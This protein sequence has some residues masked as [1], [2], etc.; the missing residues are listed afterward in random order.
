[1]LAKGKL[2]FFLLIGG[3]VV[4]A[5]LTSWLDWGKSRVDFNT[6]I[7]PI[8]NAN[9]TGCH[10]GVKQQGGISLL[11][12]ESALAK[13]KSGKPCIVPGYPDQSE[14]ILRL[15]HHD[16]DERMPLKAPPLT[17]EQIALLANW[18]KE[19]ASWE[20]H[21]AYILPVAITPPSVW[22]RW[23]ESPIDQFIYKKLD[24]EGL[25]PS[26]EADR[27]TL[28]RRVTLDL[29]GLAPTA[30]AYDA[31]LKDESD[32]AYEKVVDN[33][34][35]SPGYGERWAALWMDLA[36]YGD[37]QG[38]QKDRHR[39]IWQYRDW[40]ISAF[41]ADMPFDQFT[42]EQLAGDLLPK[43]TTEQLI[44]TAF[45]RNTS[46]NDEGGTDDEEF[47][48]V[49][50]LD[51][52]NTTMEVWQGTTIAC[53]Q[54]HSHPYDPFPHKE[55]YQLMAFFNTTQDTDR[56]DDRPTLRVLS[57]RQKADF[58]QALARF[59]A[60][61]DTASLEYKNACRDLDAIKPSNTP[62]M[63][64]LPADSSRRTF[65][66]VRGNW[67]VHGDEVFP[68]TPKMLSN[69][70]K[71]YP[72]NRLGLAQWLV[73]PQNP[74]TARVMVNRFW[75]QLFGI[76][77]VETLEDFGTQ[78]AK[79]IHPELLDW[80]ALRF[81]NE[82]QWSTKKLL[83]D[84]VLSA[85]YRQSSVVSADLQ[86]K[87]PYN[88]LLAR[89][90][91]VRLS[92]EQVRDQAL[93]AAG[94]LSQKMYGPSVM[95]PQPDG[96]WQ[97]IR[98]VV[99]WR[100]DTTQNRYRRALYTYWRK[101]SPYP[102]FVT[103]DAPSRELCVSRRIR[104]NTPLQALV[105]LNDPVYLEASQGLAGQMARSAGL[106]P[107]EN[108]RQGY[109]RLTGHYPSSERLSLLLKYYYTSINHYRKHPEDVRS[110]LTM[111]APKTAQLAALSATANVM[112][113]LDEVVTKE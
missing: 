35:K 20:T 32:D 27:A 53:V 49:A 28:L 83:K 63:Q 71:D 76:G 37:S 82:H 74:L 5:T 107:T 43:P 72:K 23:P 97:V 103:F 12:R 102:S 91:R 90:P 14:L 48:V 100:T 22:S 86:E 9:C 21:W 58:T 78:G 13:G 30:Q 96:V 19:G 6:Q 31:F 42:V 92:A 98:N 88:Y 17:D 67:M 50:V 41:N 95:P 87:D 33:L 111:A 8:L 60:L 46:T 66:F 73:S 62:I 47:R 7:R 3:G 112:L 101:S 69:L 54:C 68:Q 51:R 93:T 39:D 25:S 34:L 89:G 57:D 11:Y 2:V 113:N 106:A 80:L 105:T 77:L 110:Y 84:I 104:T 18:V 56:T 36:R 85:T 52:I 1:M 55:Y 109:F 59:S 99:K 61:K 4:L 70:P 79:P 108:I 15:R 81:M 29:T 16:P 24:D 75:E 44:A 94:L 38:Y 65:M 10:G 26:E 45:H 40:L 64:E